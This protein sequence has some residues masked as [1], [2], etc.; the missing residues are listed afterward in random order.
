MWT[1]AI[2]LSNRHSS[3]V[4]AWQTSKARSPSHTVCSSD[5]SARGQTLQAQP[6]LPAVVQLDANW[7]EG[8][9]DFAPRTRRTDK[10]DAHFAAMPCVQ[11]REKN[12]S[13]RPGRSDRD[14]TGYHCDVPT[15][16]DYRQAKRSYDIP[17]R[18]IQCGKR[19]LRGPASGTA[20]F[21][22]DTAKPLGKTCYEESFVRSACRRHLKDAMPAAPLGEYLHW[23]VVHLKLPKEEVVEVL[24][25]VA[26]WTGTCQADCLAGLPQWALNPVKNAIS[27]FRAPLSGSLDGKIR[28]KI[29]RSCLRQG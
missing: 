24:K 19:K 2:S 10:P 7:V 14:A 8:L 29:S 12:K 26:Q 9:K 22:I 27:L 28:Y 11:L 25:L 5:P 18:N 13:A 6:V 3:T 20:N 1:G 15:G 17:V 21:C 4:R 16:E 23:V